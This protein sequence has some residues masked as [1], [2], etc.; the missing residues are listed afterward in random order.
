MLVPDG[1]PWRDGAE[2]VDRVAT[3][4]ATALAVGAPWP[5][6]ALWWDTDH[7]GF[8]LASG[9][10]RP[11]GFVWLA[12]GVPAG[13]DEAMRTFAARLG[14]DPVLDVQDLDRPAAPDQAAD[15]R[16]RL[17]GLLAVLARVLAV[18]AR[19]G[20]SLPAELA[21]GSPQAASGKPPP[22]GRTAC[23]SSGP[24]IARRARH[25]TPSTTPASAPGCPGRAAPGAA[26]WPWRR[27][28]RA[29]RSWSEACEARAA[30]GPR[31]G[32]CSSRTARWA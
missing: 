29:C 7:A 5:G 28:R 21:P 17:R 4:W 6:L 26:P 3:G 18:L 9:F 31:P 23:P 27:W 1:R 12:S 10:R 11:V 19:V 16:T 15:A 8:T 30:A 20:V 14:L 13:E 24:A 25:R 2:P 22:D 32:H